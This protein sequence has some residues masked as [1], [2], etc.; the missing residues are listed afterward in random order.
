MH[1][2]IAHAR[3]AS[4]THDV[5]SDPETQNSHGIWQSTKL[6]HSADDTTMPRGSSDSLE[7]LAQRKQVA[8]RVR[9]QIAG[10]SKSAKLADKREL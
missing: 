6:L 8:R 7:G 9:A 2:I 10:K 4:K 1:R 5:G 3:P